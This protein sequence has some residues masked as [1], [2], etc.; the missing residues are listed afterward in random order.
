[1]DG[2]I[3][4]Y[5]FR[6]LDSCDSSGLASEDFEVEFECYLLSMVFCFLLS[7]KGRLIVIGF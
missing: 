1:M 6:M 5:L 3:L 2:D 7:I 4:S